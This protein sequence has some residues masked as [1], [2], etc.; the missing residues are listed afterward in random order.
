MRYWKRIWHLFGVGCGLTRFLAIAGTVASISSSA[1][2]DRSGKRTLDRGETGTLSAVDGSLIGTSR[3]S[4]RVA[5]P[6]CRVRDVGGPPYA[7][8]EPHARESDD[9]DSLSSIYRTM[10]CRYTNKLPRG[11][12]KFSYSIQPLYLGILS[13]F[14]LG[15]TKFAKYRTFDFSINPLKMTLHIHN[16]P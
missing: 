15:I 8:L 7:N 5:R 4:D 1:G 14:G 11:R 6:S 9:N 12:G 2:V 16:S 10:Q 13:C 3:R